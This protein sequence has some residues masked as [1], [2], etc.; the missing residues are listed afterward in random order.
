[1]AKKP[2]VKPAVPAPQK[3]G[4]EYTT[5]NVQGCCGAYY[6]VRREA[7]VDSSDEEA[8]R[9]LY[10]T[11]SWFSLHENYTRELRQLEEG[12]RRF[13]A[14]YVDHLKTLIERYSFEGWVA[15]GRPDGFQWSRQIPT[16][17]PGL[18]I[19]NAPLEGFTESPSGRLWW[20]RDRAPVNRTSRVLKPHPKP[21]EGAAPPEFWAHFNGFRPSKTPFDDHYHFVGTSFYSPRTCRHYG[22]EETEPEQWAAGVLQRLE[23]LAPGTLATCILNHSQRHGKRPSMAGAQVMQMAGFTEV[24]RTGNVN[25]PGS[26]TIY[27][28]EKVV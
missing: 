18:A 20:R 24:C 6:I 10:R 15:S 8:I 14:S 26:S 25:H 12:G 9:K 1:M 16:Y 21:P 13:H 22:F 3:E 7:V 28:F 2:L 19:S 4:F 5:A 11:T 27:L 23:G 17:S